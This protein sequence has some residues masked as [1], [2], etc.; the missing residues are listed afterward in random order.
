VGNLVAVTNA[1]GQ[2]ASHTYDVRNRLTNTVWSYGTG[3]PPVRSAPT[4][5]RSYDLAGRLK[6]LNNG[7]TAEGYVY[8]AANQLL[9]ETNS[10]SGTGFL[11][12][13]YG[14]TV[15]YGYDLDGRKQKLVYPSGNALTNTFTARG[16]VKGLYENGSQSAAFSYDLNG[17]RTALAL[18]NGVNTGYGYD[19]ASRLTSILSATSGGAVASFAYTYNVINDRTAVSREDGRTENY[20]YDAAEQLTGVFGKRDQRFADRSPQPAPAGRGGHARR[21]PPKVRCGIAVQR[22]TICQPTRSQFPLP[23][24][25]GRVRENAP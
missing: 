16:Q 25:E 21:V 9:S 8:D 1:A 17:N 13:N 6:T 14:Y 3:F 12:V 23:A 18:N 20:G 11:P 15:S 5:A 22:V 4:V 10:I 19:A 7:N 2:V 24:E